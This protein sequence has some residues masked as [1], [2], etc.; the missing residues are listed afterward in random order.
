MRNPAIYDVASHGL[1]TAFWKYS[2]NFQAEFSQDGQVAGAA[3]AV[4]TWELK[5]TNVMTKVREE[6]MQIK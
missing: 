6:N 2:E 3:K 5:N 4:R 1:S